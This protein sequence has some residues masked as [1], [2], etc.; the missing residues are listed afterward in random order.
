M[1][2]KAV[3]VEKSKDEGRPYQPSDELIVEVNDVFK[4]DPLEYVEDEE[5]LTLI[6]E[7]QR[8]IRKNV[9]YAQAGG[10]RISKNVALGKDKKTTGTVEPTDIL[11]ALLDG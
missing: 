9:R 8:G 1:V 10:K 6:V 3:D 11:G 4:K 5:K 2:K 7:Y